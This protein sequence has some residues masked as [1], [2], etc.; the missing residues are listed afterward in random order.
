LSTESIEILR[1]KIKN[2]GRIPQHVAVIMDGNGRWAKQRGLSRV[3]GHEEGIK[4]VR[5][6]VEACGELG[7]DV[8]TLYTFSTE[9]WQRPKSEVTALMRLLLRTIRNEVNELN[10]NN[11]RIMTIG[12]LEDL[13]IAARKAV[14]DITSKLRNNTGLTVNLALS[15]GARLEIL[16]AV[17]SI[18]EK[19]QKGELSVDNIDE[20]TMSQYLQTHSI[21]DPDLLIRTSGEMRLSNFLLWQLAYTEIYVSETLWPDFRKAE[22]Y[23]AI[24]IYQQRE[25][26]FGKVS[27]QLDKVTG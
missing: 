16:D 22:F 20:L 6:V 7:I 23:K 18:T 3:D 12:R 21:P 4:S 14:K 27:E 10:K 26:R 5:A 13:P 8:L 25:R 24:E 19:V 2:R 11:V 1:E 9:N 17:K 15:Y